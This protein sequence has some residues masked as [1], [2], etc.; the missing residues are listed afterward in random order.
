MDGDGLT[1]TQSVRLMNTR[2]K[3]F[4]SLAS[5]TCSPS[6]HH[7]KHHCPPTLRGGAWWKL[8][9]LH[10]GMHLR[11]IKYL[12]KFISVWGG[13]SVLKCCSSQESAASPV[14]GLRKMVTNSFLFFFFKG[15]IKRK[16]QKGLRN[17]GW[18]HRSKLESEDSCFR[19][20]CWGLLHNTGVLS[21][22]IITLLSAP[23]TELCLF[24]LP[25]SFLSP[26]QK[27]LGKLQSSQARV[28]EPAGARTRLAELPPWGNT[29]A[30]NKDEQCCTYCCGCCIPYSR[31]LFLLF[32][33]L[34]SLRKGCTPTAESLN[35]L[36]QQ[37][38]SLQP[39]DYC[40]A[41]GDFPHLQGV[42][43]KLPA[44][45]AGLTVARTQQRLSLAPAQLLRGSGSPGWRHEPLPSLCSPQESLF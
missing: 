21:P 32:Q 16:K 44:L 26:L 25:H 23:G 12:R 28:V 41:V 5:R 22:F 35:Q 17:V 33:C 20:C 29:F 27:F 38:T 13:C 43:S 24:R 40:P 18:Q 7:W 15:K 39:D 31:Q 19:R 37:D 6:V 34:V 14:H 11:H 36:P 30:E 9:L 10:S 8:V 3:S 4:C 45:L 2:G 1:P 42:L